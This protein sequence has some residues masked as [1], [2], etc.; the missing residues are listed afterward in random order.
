MI[1]NDLV[2]DYF[3]LS[4]ELIEGKSIDGTWR[5]DPYQIT[6]ACESGEIQA[7]KFNL[8]A[9]RRLRFANS[10]VQIANMIHIAQ[11]MD[12]CTVHLPAYWFLNSTS[13]RLSIGLKI[14]IADKSPPEGIT[15]AGAF[16]YLHSLLPICKNTKPNRYKILQEIK[17]YLNLG[18]S[19]N[20]PLGDKDL[21]IHVRYGDIFSEQKV[22][23]GYGQPPFSYYKKVIESD[24]WD[25]IYVVFEDL[26][27]PVINLI[28]DYC[29][30]NDIRSDV[31][32]GELKSDIDF[33][34]RARNIVAGRGTFMAGVLALS[35]CV[36]QVYI[37]DSGFSTWGNLNP[38]VTKITDVTGE[39]KRAVLSNN[40][41]NS[42]SQRQLMCTYPVEHLGFS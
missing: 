1:M 8:K 26:K 33:L 36:Q 40:W 35:D 22:H 6:C 13:F 42:E 27:N 9:T 21:V 2:Y 7:M 3:K 24:S 38:R 12:G 34:L 28:L 15:F 16:F 31:V 17:P 30:N 14:L 18:L 39:F 23:P 5:R 32:S 25:R 29:I 11:H 4:R 41:S 19:T 10:L 37:F 20:H